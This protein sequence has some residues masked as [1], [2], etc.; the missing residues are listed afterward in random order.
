M[1]RPIRIAMW[2]NILLYVSDSPFGFLIPSFMWKKKKKLLKMLHDGKKRVEKEL[3]IVKIMKSIRNVK[4][5]MKNSLLS[6][7]VKF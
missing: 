4:I 3:D 6:K 5:L 7:D 1:H 2:E